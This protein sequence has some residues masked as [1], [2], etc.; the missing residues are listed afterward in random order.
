MVVTGAPFGVTECGSNSQSIPSGT[1]V[2][3]N[4]TV[5]L[6]PFAGVTVTTAIPACDG[7]TVTLEGVAESVK[8]PVAAV[9]LIDTAVEVDIAKFASPPYCAVIECMPA[10][11]VEVA[12]VAEPEPFNVPGPKVVWPSRNVTVPVGTFVPLAGVT[13]AINETLA[14]VV[15]VAG[16]VNI[17]VVA[18]SAAAFTVCVNA[19][20]VSAA[21]FASPPYCAVIECDPCT[22]ADVMNV[23]FPPAPTVPIPREVIPSKNVTVPLIVPAVAEETVAVN[24]TL[25]PAV[26]GFKDDVTNEVVAAFVPAFTVS[27]SASEVLAENLASPLY[28]AVIEWTAC[29]SVVV[30][31]DALPLLIVTGAPICVA[32]SKNVIVPVSVPAV[33]DVDVAVNVTLWP[34]VAGFSDDTT[35]VDVAAVVAA[36]TVCVIAS[37]VLPA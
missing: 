10:A 9:M 25:V 33:V 4:C 7:V 12:N 20:E 2:H 27:L 24:V 14:P 5:W 37:E 28:F 21:K 36:F 35:V 16:P 30:E 23:A 26:D 13:L 6:K 15:P 19:G 17:V 8:L 32:P 18:M 31:I 11:N 34:T 29:V 1:F 22:S 3:E